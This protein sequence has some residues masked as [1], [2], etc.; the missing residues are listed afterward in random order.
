MN[1]VKIY[2]LIDPRFEVPFYVGATQLEL[3]IRVAQHISYAKERVHKKSDSYK[4]DSLINEILSERKRVKIVL[5]EMVAIKDASK[6]E[7]K[8]YLKYKKDGYQIYQSAHSFTYT[9]NSATRNKT[10]LKKEGVG[11]VQLITKNNILNRAS[12]KANSEGITL[13]EKIDR[14]LFKYLFGKE[15]GGIN[16]GNNSDAFRDYLDIRGIKWKPNGSF[17]TVFWD[18]PFD[19]GEEWGIYKYQ[20]SPLYKE[21]REKSNDIANGR[22]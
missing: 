9:Q 13:S 11:Q 21:V 4:R 2:A 22:D 10:L 3:K 14:D 8:Y 19:L 7:K 18:K 5:L 20:N 6:V 17:T 16:V 12:K 1:K 15:E